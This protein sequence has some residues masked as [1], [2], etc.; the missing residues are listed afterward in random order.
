MST[1][2]TREE[3]LDVGANPTGSIR[4]GNMSLALIRTQIATVIKAATSLAN[5]VYE[6]KRYSADFDSYKSLFKE[7][8]IIH[9]WDIERPHVSKDQHGGHGGQEDSVHTFMVRGFYRLNDSLASEKTF[10]DIVEDVIQAFIED[11]QLG[12]TATTIEFPIEADITNVMFAHVLCHK[13]E[14]TINVQE[15]RIF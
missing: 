10:N 5:T 8:E 4:K 9:T 15:R 13:A 12:A 11:I 14:I 2:L 1:V 7:N 3:A 6:Y